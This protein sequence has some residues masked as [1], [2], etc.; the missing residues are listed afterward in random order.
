M[1]SYF[2]ETH[3]RHV[4]HDKKFKKVGLTATAALICS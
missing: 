3:F 2:T 1:E 4:I